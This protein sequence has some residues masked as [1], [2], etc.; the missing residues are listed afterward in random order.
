MKPSSPNSRF[1]RKE[2]GSVIVLVLVLVFLTAMLLTK[3]I[4]STSVELML[5]TQHADRERL[6]QEAHSALEVTLATLA[7]F[8]AVDHGLYTPIQGWS[9]PL[10]YAGYTP[11]EGVTV[12]V[13][14]EDESGKISLPTASRDTLFNLFERLGLVEA[15]ANQVTDAL[16]FWMHDGYVPTNSA[17]DDAAY[18]SAV[19]PYQPAHRS[20]RTFDELKV[21]LGAR[22]F[23]FD[24]D[25]Q[26]KPL[27]D[28][29]RGSVSLYA[30]NASNINANQA[31]TLGAAQLDDSQSALI[32]NYVAGKGD[33]IA[34]A[35]PY[36]RN[37]KDVSTV[38]GNAPTSGL[39]TTIQCLRIKITVR[40]GASNMVLN[41]LV[42]QPGKATYPAMATVGDLTDDATTQAQTAATAA[43]STATGDTTATGTTTRAA[44]TSTL[45]YP[46]VILQL[47]EENA[48]PSAPATPNA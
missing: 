32:A 29:F 34:G 9:D 19:L 44:R 46:F 37:A 14:F 18:S 13:A 4:E 33:R 47:S 40:E 35:P 1:R 3:F 30:F 25:D 21:V 43:A 36:L 38:L 5:E 42:A 16:F 31:N 7:D 10:G 27:F 41:A 2:R 26:P 24:S 45:S 20:L 12:D 23:F 22:D 6:R 8:L 11:R 28:A 48:P 17:I 39:G 15:D